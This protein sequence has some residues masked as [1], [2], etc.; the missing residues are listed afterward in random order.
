MC[1]KSIGKII[2]DKDVSAMLLLDVS[3]VAIGVVSFVACARGDRC[4]L[5]A[6]MAAN[7]LRVR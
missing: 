2:A 3:L 4:A 6:C 7:C 1:E 5:A